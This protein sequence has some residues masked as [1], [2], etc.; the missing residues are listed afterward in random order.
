MTAMCMPRYLLLPARANI[1]GF[2]RSPIWAARFRQDGMG[3]VSVS[4]FSYTQGDQPR[5]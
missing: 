2:E 4:D 3:I 1:L 5:S